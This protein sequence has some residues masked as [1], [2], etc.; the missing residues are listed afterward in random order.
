M[1]LE[2]VLE[3]EFEVDAAMVVVVGPGAVAEHLLALGLGPAAMVAD[4]AG[5]QFGAE[6]RPEAVQHEMHAAAT[7]E[8]FVVDKGSTAGKIAGMDHMQDTADNI[9][10]TVVDTTAQ[11]LSQQLKCWPGPEDLH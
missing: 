7:A 8:Q 6:H 9:A 2:A 5:L 4:G 3:Q 10:E 11:Q 1:G